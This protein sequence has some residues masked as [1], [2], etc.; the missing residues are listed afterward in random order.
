MRAA[1]GAAAREPSGGRRA[2][3][4]RRSRNLVIVLTVS[5]TKC[6][7]SSGQHSAV[8]AVFTVPVL[9]I[10]VLTVPVPVPVLGTHR[11]GCPGERPSEG[12]FPFP[13]E[14]DLSWRR[15][16]VLRRVAS[17]VLSLRDGWCC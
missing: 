4:S 10:S 7:R 12:T 13:P 15:T 17:A 8:L 5:E 6:P 2:A 14:V 1:R 9:G 11:H 3:R 16:W